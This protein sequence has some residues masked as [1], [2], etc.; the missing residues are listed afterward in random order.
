M[1]WTALFSLLLCF[2]VGVAIGWVL[3]SNRGNA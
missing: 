3:W 2:L 1:F